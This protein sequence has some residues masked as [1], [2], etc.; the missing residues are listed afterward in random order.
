MSIPLV[1]ISINLFF[2]QSFFIKIIFVCLFL[3]VLGLRCCTGYSLVVVLLAVVLHTRSRC[4]HRLSSC[5]TWAYWSMARGTFPDQDRTC[6]SCID[7]QILYHWATGKLLHSFYNVLGYHSVPKP[8][9]ESKYVLF[10]KDLSV[11]VCMCVREREK[12]RERERYFGIFQPLSSFCGICKLSSG[13]I[14]QAMFI[15]H[16]CNSKNFQALD[17]TWC[18]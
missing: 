18:W 7:R 6:V 4:E 3:A 14:H 10:S 9:V 2:S 8:S 11:C 12:E 17:F 16:F 13:K 1:T 5:G 15:Y